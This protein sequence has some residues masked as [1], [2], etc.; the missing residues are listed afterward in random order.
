MDL[1][2]F[3]FFFSFCNI[4]LGLHNVHH[5]NA[6]GCD[7]QY[8][9]ETKIGTHLLIF[10]FSSIIAAPSQLARPA[11]SGG[12]FRSGTIPRSACLRW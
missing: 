4:Q 9:A 12:L 5:L 7:V 1:L 8:A 6:F 11:L 10:T 2:T 3:C